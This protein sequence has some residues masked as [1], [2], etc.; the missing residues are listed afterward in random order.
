M[1]ITLP[2]SR[3]FS[4]VFQKATGKSISEKIDPSPEIIEIEK[5]K[6]SLI[7]QDYKNAL[8]HLYRAKKINPNSPLI[9]FYEGYIYI[10]QKKLKES[11]GTSPNAF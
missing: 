9:L 4:K 2:N 5:S 1:R 10:Q 11:T 8:K 7:K 6:M 3:T